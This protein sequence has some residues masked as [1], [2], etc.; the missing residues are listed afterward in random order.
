MRFVDLT[1]RRFGKLVVK[2][3]S[4]R[5]R[6][7]TRWNCE[8]DCGK[9]TTLSYSDLIRKDEK[10]VSS[11]GCGRRAKDLTGQKFGKLLV[12]RRA[13]D[14]LAPSGKLPRWCCRCD[15][16]NEIEVYGCNLKNGKSK[17]CSCYKKKPHE[18]A[19]VNSIWHGYRL[20]AKT[21][22]RSFELTIAAFKSLLLQKCHYCGS[23]PSCKSNGEK[24]NG[25]FL[26]NGIDRVDNAKGYVEGNCV[27]CC[28]LCNQSKNTLSKVAFLAH[29]RK[30][31]LH[32]RKAKSD[33]RTDSLF[34]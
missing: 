6:P 8:C 33:E 34:S 23:L 15:C 27:P 18:V 28:K 14:Q 13:Q 2:S 30:I 20:K 10:R 4:D 17:G 32:A 31:Y 1:G 3:L 19:F 5:P 7:P 29:I 21:K 24:Y 26:R 9:K 25:S 22:G 16:G 12:L 11:C